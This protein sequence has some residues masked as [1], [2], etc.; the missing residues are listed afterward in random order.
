MHTVSFYFMVH[1]CVKIHSS[2]KTSPAMEAG[3]TTFLS[4]MEEI[5]VMAETNG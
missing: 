2:M 5:A 3:V 1:N 4:S